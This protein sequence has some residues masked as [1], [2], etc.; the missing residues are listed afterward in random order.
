VVAIP[1]EIGLKGYIS[2]H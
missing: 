2:V 1:Q